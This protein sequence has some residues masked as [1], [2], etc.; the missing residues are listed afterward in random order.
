MSDRIAD[1]AGD[2]VLSEAW[3]AALLLEVM[4]RLD[5]PLRR[6]LL[7][8]QVITPPYAELPAREDNLAWRYVPDDVLAGLRLSEHR[9][10]CAVVL[11]GAQEEKR[12]ARSGHKPDLV[13]RNWKLSGVA[14]Y[15]RDKAYDED[16]MG[17]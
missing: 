9:H 3:A 5:A 10:P 14:P 16:G 2:T 6:E 15:G 8:S 7:M 4:L 12:R 13:V 11:R 17:R 1:N